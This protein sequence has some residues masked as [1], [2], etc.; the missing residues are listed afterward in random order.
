MSDSDL[1]LHSSINSQT[2]VI[3]EALSLGSVPVIEDNETACSDLRGAIALLKRHRAPVIFVNS[4]I[5]Q[6]KTIIDNEKKMSDQEKVV[7]RAAVINWYCGFR[8][9]MASTFVKMIA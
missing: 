4:I 9:A 1:T 6:L 3:Y 2:S 5:D 8:K 7:R